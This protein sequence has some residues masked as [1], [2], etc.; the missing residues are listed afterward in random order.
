[1]VLAF[2]LASSKSRPHPQLNDFHNRNKGVPPSIE[3]S[4]IRAKREG[5]VD[6]GNF[7]SMM[8]GFAQNLGRGINSMVQQGHNLGHRMVHSVMHNMPD[9]IYGNWKPISSPNPKPIY[10][11]PPPP[12]PKPISP[13]PQYVVG[14]AA[15]PSNYPS[16]VAPQPTPSSSYN[17]PEPT[18]TPPFKPIY[19]IPDPIIV[20]P[21]PIKKPEPVYVK[22]E[23]VYVPAVSPSPSPSPSPE[24]SYVSS[25]ISNTYEIVA[26][27]SFSFPEEKPEDDTYGTPVGQTI[28]AVPAPVAA[29]PAPAVP[30]AIP[31]IP[32]V[33]DNHVT[34]V[35]STE[36]PIIITTETPQE[37]HGQII[38]SHIPEEYSQ[39][40][41]HIHHITGDTLFYKDLGKLKEKLKMVEG[42]P[43]HFHAKTGPSSKSHSHSF[44]L[45]S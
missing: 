19:T 38:I 1:M 14:P 41:D 8:R 37:L 13:S 23:P 2:G 29:V 22:P 26:S 20:K 24:P 18:Y 42:K 4:S 7:S 3:E 12:Q 10:P 36:R 6:L 25:T 35:Q 15:P 28:D 17:H 39:N 40:P 31:A 21:K 34:T 43:V 32:A 30:E 27:D 45:R 9:I 33:P 16:P 44:I 5:F 11:K